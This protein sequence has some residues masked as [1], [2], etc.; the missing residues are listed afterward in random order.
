MLDR[1]ND[2]NYFVYVF[3]AGQK[4]IHLQIFPFDN[5]SND[6]KMEEQ[7]EALK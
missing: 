1:Q 5:A 4:Y 2:P 7:I 3:C 6:I